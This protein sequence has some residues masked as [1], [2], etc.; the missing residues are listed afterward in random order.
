MKIIDCFTFYNEIELLNYRLNILNDY[1]DNFILV[2]ATHTHV[3]REKEL[4]FEKNKHLFEIFKDKIIH[5]VVNDFLYISTDKTNAVEYENVWKNENYQRNCIDNGI[6]KLNLT[7]DDIIVISDLDEIPDP[8]VFKK[9]KN[10]EIMIEFNSLEMDFYYYNLNSKIH[11]KWYKSKILSYIHYINITENLKLNCND[12]RT[13]IEVSKPNY[14]IKNGGWHLSF[15]GNSKHI[16]NKIENFSHQEYNNE[17][18]INVENIQEK[19]NTSKD[20]FDRND[21]NISKIYVNDN[22]Y[23]PPKYNTY[24]QKF[25][26]F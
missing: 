1:V 21:C 23:L 22:L 26:L 11:D 2:E 13:K 16:K 19:I 7:N 14:I 10:N 12:I 15:F 5:V 20:L 18:I 8:N 25:V 9:I 6:K 17:K 4:M 3:G 24:L